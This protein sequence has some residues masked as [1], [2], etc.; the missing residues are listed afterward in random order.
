MIIGVGTDIIKIKR[1]QQAALNIKFLNRIFTESEIAEYV[2]K[3]KKAQTLA[4]KFAAKEAVSKCFKT[5]FSGFWPKEIEVLSED[6]P[7]VILHGKAK[8]IG[9]NLGIS[10]IHVSI[11][12]TDDN[13]VAFAVAEGK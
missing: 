13:A 3:G 6:E 2:Q 10:N 4:G 5:G 7:R 8:E 1:I 9:N 11:S 12:H